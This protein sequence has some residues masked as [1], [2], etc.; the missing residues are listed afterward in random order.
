MKTETSIIFLNKARSELDRVVALIS[1]PVDK[2]NFTSNLLFNREIAD[3]IS[4]LDLDQ[5]AEEIINNFCP[6][7]G[8]D[9]EKK[10]KLCPHCGTNLLVSFT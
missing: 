4:Y 6:K 1:D 2:K 8:M 9:N 5:K 3:N 7:C 10:I